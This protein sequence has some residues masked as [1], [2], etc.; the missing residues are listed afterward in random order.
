M[1]IATMLAASIILGPLTGDTRERLEGDRAWLMSMECSIPKLS[2]AADAAARAAR[3]EMC[4]LEAHMKDAL[5]DG[6]IVLKQED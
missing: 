6:P 2:P 4:T 3:K 1:H 5:R